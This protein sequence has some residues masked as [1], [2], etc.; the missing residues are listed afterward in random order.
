MSGHHPFANLTKD[1]TPER[2]ARV[3]GRAA[4]LNESLPPEGPH[5][6][7]QE[8]ADTTTPRERRKR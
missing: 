7:Q 5:D 2:R 4:A 8:D 1:F 3:A 6:A